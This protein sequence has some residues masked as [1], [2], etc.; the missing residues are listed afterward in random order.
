M[1][2]RRASQLIRIV[3]IIS[4]FLIGGY[5]LFETMPLATFLLTGQR[6]M[7]TLVQLP[8]FDPTSNVGYIL[9]VINQTVLSHFVV[10]VNVGVECTFAMIIN[11]MWIGVD[12]IRYS[13]DEMQDQLQSN[14]DWL[15]HRKRFRNILIQI[16]DLDR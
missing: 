4:G 2:N 14:G 16:Q 6:T 1:M 15:Q 3:L 8:Y 7:V 12:I 11:S 9:N 13:V 10:F 5:V